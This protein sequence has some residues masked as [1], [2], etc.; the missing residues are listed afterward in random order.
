MQDFLQNNQNP[1]T[2]QNEYVSAPRR[3][4]IDTGIVSCHFWDFYLIASDAPADKSRNPIRCIVVYDGLNLAGTNK[5]NEDE[6]DDDDDD[7]KDNYKNGQNDLEFL[8]YALCNLY[9]NWGGTV[10]VPH[11]T[12]YADKIASFYSEHGFSHQTPH[13][14]LMLYLHYL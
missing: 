13:E 9:Y 8:T 3:V 4:V 10:K 1:N 2:E 5:N 11:V 12:K 7:N 6:D 14:N